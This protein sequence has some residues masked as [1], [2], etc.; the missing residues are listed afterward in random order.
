MHVVVWNAAD[1]SGTSAARL[2]VSLEARQ[3]VHID[4]ADS[5]SIAFKC[6]DYAETLSIIESSTWVTAATAR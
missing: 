3:T 4:S 6:G 5:K 2:R 1:T